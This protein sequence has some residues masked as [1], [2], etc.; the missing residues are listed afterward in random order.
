MATEIIVV[1]QDR[2]SY[3]RSR[4]RRNS[5]RRSRL[6]GVNSY[7]R[8]RFEQS[9]V[10]REQLQAESATGVREQLQAEHLLAEQLQA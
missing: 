5:Y 3:T 1:L 7:G 8:S 6:T 9:S 2:M 4:V 10:R